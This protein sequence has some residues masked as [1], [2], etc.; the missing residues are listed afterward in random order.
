M[1]DHHHSVEQQAKLTSGR[2]FWTTKP[3]G[4]LGSIMLT[5]GPH[6]LRKQEGASDH[7]GL[8]GSVAA[9]CFP[10]AVGL[11]QTWDVDLAE[12]VGAAIA[13]EARA[14]GVSVVLGPGVN[15]K[16]SPLGGRNFEYFS[17]DP[18]LTGRLGAAWVRGLQGRGVGASLKHFAVNNQETDRMRIS[19]D[20]DER[21]LHELYLR[22]FRHIVTTEQ[23]WTVMCS[24]NR[25]NGVPASQ[26]RE[27]L[28]T[29]LRE[30][31]GFDG[32]VVSDWG[33]VADRVRALAAGLDLTMPFPGEASDAEVVTAVTSGELAV[34]ALRSSAQRVTR[35]VERAATEPA[36][37]I[38][39][40]AHH[41]LAHE[42]ATRAIVL[43]RN[44]GNLLPLQR[45]TSVAVIGALAAQP[46]YQGGGSSHVNA[47]RV[48]IPLDAIRAFAE[49]EVGFAAGYRLDGQPS[50]QLRT[51]AEAAARSA[52]RVVLFLGLADGQESEGF[53]RST[54]ELP[55]DQ[56]GLATAV[57][58]ANPATVVVLCHGGALRVTPLRA[59]AI[60]DAALLGQAV[61][62]AIA[63]VLYGAVN[64]SG[65]LAETLPRRIEDTPAHLSFPGEHGHVTYGEGLYIGYRWYDARDLDVA[66]P[67]GHGLSYTTFDYR[68][69]VVSEDDSGIAVSLAVTNTGAVSGREVVQVYVGVDDASV[70]RAPRELK[71][72]TTVDLGAGDTAEVMLHID[73]DSLAYWD[74]RV[75]EFV[76]EGGTYRVSVG[77]SSRDIRLCATVDI[78]GDDIRV[79]LTLESSIGEAL[80]DPVA[81]EGLQSIVGAMFGGGDGG[82]SA[83]GVDVAAMMESVPLGRLVGFSGGLLSREMLQQI[84]D[85]ANA[86]H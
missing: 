86:G 8:S 40:D 58:D 19:A 4:G 53:D 81:A 57:F 6:G 32:A 17:E 43:L 9:T 77:A 48:D 63:D 34:A 56:L 25:I 41:T 29:I 26:S 83:F 1:T 3:E 42:A 49:H 47:P 85:R 68:D 69:L 51:E 27:L 59:P 64:P 16:R 67:F 50:G 71:A 65:R 72:F 15:L 46:R 31:W 44:D 28:T 45:N 79:P 75:H 35:L 37:P 73:R 14:Q 23:P 52:D 80:A 11:A 30:Q 10:P 74:I 7:L 82:G 13:D 62:S 38:D 18:F 20:V 39:F 66:H 24:Y 12:R 33:A 78:A 61:G 76:V 54:I 21:T 60:V 36:P 5:D 55:D 22:A 84:L 70:V 2:D